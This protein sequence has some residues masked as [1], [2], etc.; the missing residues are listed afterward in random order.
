MPFVA[1]A[2]HPNALG[3]VQGHDNLVATSGK[4]SREHIAV[5]LVVFYDQD[6]LHGMRAVRGSEWE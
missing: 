5:H 4:S 1:T 6:L 2:G 3:T